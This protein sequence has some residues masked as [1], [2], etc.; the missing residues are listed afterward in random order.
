MFTSRSRLRRR[1]AHDRSVTA[2]V[3]GSVVVVVAGSAAQLIDYAFFDLRISA[4]NSAEDGGLFGAIGDLAAIA[5]AGAG[6]FL[7]VR[8]RPRPPALIALPPLL[9][10]IAVDKAFRVHDHIPH[11]LVLYAPVLTA[12]FACLLITARLVPPPM[13]RL[14]VVGLVLL[15]VSFVLHVIGERV[16]V[17]FGVGDAPLAHQIKAVVKHGCE[18]EAWLLL[19]IGLGFSAIRASRARGFS[20]REAAARSNARRAERT[21]W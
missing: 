14:L 7:L 13:A 17:G 18:V 20:R 12:A 4:L 3:A 21:S 8:V 11:Y 1:R 2:C 15:A 16:L 9:T 6:W 10:F 5:A 19:T